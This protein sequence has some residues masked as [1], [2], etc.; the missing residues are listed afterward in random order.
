[1]DTAKIMIVE[2]EAITALDLKSRLKRAGYDVVAMV[3]SGED[4]ISTAAE[5]RPDLVLMDIQMPV[6][7]GISATTEIRRMEQETGE[8]IPIIA[9][10]ANVM[11]GDRERSLEAGCDGYIQKPLDVDAL[12]AQISKF[13]VR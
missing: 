4:A 8:H 5:H 2:D 3:S 1:M 13:L 7:D 10:T 6:M 12:P 9:I 11:K